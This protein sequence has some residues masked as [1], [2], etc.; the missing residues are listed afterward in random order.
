MSKQ[1]PTHP[2]D[3]KLAGA[4]QESHRFDEV[5]LCHVDLLYRMA[6]RLSGNRHDAEDL[7]QETFLRAH[8]A[9]AGFKLHEFG[10]KPW[11]L[12]I[13]HNVFVTRLGQTR[14]VP[15]LSDGADPDELAQDVRRP[16]ALSDAKEKVDW[17]HL[18]EE[19]QRALDSLAPEYRTV[20][21]LWALGELSYKEIADVLDCAMGTVMSRLHRARRQLAGL[22]REYAAER[23]IRLK[24]DQE[25]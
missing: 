6:F 13:M 8:R 19:L 11:L 18:D 3:P 12:R 7:V 14:R 2:T 23:G 17:E 15:L 21:M 4:A 10:A 25:Q 16:S 24:P 1:E 5:V 22:L 20:L 9:F